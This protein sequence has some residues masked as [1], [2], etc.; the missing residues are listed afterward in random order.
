MALLTV[1]TAGIA[2]VVPTTPATPT[3]STGDTFPNT[4]R[5]V[6][7]VVNGAVSPITVT[8]D[9][10]R[11]SDGDGA[12]VSDPTV[13]VTN[14]T[15]QFIGPFPTTYNDANGRVKITCSSVTSI[16]VTVLKVPALS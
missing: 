4:G 11:T 10:Q 8:I 15:R 5:E 6:V 16:T 2:G 9:V 1:A 3:A 12:T 7:E 13:T 14:G